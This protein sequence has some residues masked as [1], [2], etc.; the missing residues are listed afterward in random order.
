MEKSVN[1][2]II[3]VIMVYCLSWFSGII[4]MTAVPVHNSH[5]KDLYPRLHTAFVWAVT[6][7]YFDGVINPFIYVYRCDNIE[8]EFFCVGYEEKGFPG[9]TRRSPLKS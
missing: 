6:M 4:I 1:R 3:A 9:I 5:S 8:R 2:S 7:S